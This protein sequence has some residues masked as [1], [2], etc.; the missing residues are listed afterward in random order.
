M[1]HVYLLVF[2]FAL[3]QGSVS[4][5]Q[6]CAPDPQYASTPGIFPDSATNFVSGTVGVPY[7]Q[8]ITVTVP[9]D[10]T[11][12]TPPFTTTIPFDSVHLVSIV[13][14]PPGLTYMCAPGICTWN[15]GTSGCSA[16]YGTPTTAGTYSLNI[17]IKAY[18]G[19]STTPINETITYY[20]I[21]INPA[22]G[23]A[24]NT[25]IPFE[26]KQ[27]SPNPFSGKTV[28]Q[29]TVP[30]DEKVKFCVY[31][32]LGKLVMDKKI[33]AVRGNNELEVDGKQLS[34]GMYFYT[35]EYKGKTITR[36]MMVSND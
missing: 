14:L 13:N 22:V 32:T 16:I 11:I 10:T 6:T 28:L 24:E 31:N 20:R 25:V 34:G 12:G 36:R 2:V 8:N 23:I 3:I 21:I 30:T 19:G 15:G 29:Y 17:S 9:V 5:G 1:K 4:F 18:V 26:V 33:D 27:N 7:N 35:I